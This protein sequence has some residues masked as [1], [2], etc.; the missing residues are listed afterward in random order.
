MRA[1]ILK[2]FSTISN[3]LEKVNWVTIITFITMKKV[4]I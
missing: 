2:V 1:V 3:F 4:A